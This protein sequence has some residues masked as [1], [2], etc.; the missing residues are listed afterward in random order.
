NT[1]LVVIAILSTLSPLGMQWAVC[2]S[3]A[4]QCQRRMAAAHEVR[5]GAEGLLIGDEYT[6][7]A[8]SGNYLSA[9]WIE[10]GT[11]LMHQFSVAYCRV[12]PANNPLTLPSS[13]TAELPELQRHLAQACPHASIALG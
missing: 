2:R 13:S 1:T 10:A 5:L 6:P 3:I 7:W 12:C 8:L 11:K 9:A 4:S